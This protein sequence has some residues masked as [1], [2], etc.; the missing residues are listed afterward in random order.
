[1][2]KNNSKFL[3]KELLKIGYDIR[4]TWYVNSLR[5]LNNN[6]EFNDF[7]NCENLNE[8]VLS[9]PTHDKISKEDIVKISKLINFFEK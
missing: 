5:Y 7:T 3:S 1:M 6:Y 8:K 9:L 4:H 2:K